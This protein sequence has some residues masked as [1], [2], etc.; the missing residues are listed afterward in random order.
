METR[1]KSFGLHWRIVAVLLLVSLLPLG[2]VGIGS[3]I[4]FSDLLKEKTLELHRSIVQTHA[5]SIDL[6]LAERLRALDLVAQSHELEVLSSQ[7]VLKQLLHTIN[8][9]YGMSFIDLGVI[10]EDGEHLSYTGP[11]ELHDKNYINEPWF[12]AVKSQ[13]AYV[14]DVFLGFRLVPHCIIAVKRHQ[15]AHWW[16]LRATIN[17]AE[18][19]KLVQPGQIGKTGDTFIVNSEGLYQTPSKSGKVMEKSSITS[20]Q[21]HAEVQH[22]RVSEHG[23][24]MLRATSWLNAG[25]WMLVVQQNEAEIQAP[26][27]HAMLRGFLVILVAVGLVVG[28]TIFATWHLTG[29]IDQANA[30]REK[31]SRD[32][33][34]SAKLAS[35]GEISS[36]LAHEINNPLAIMGAEH[37]NIADMV[38]ELDSDA[39][40]RDE[41]LESIDRCKRQVERCG[42]ITAKMLQFGRNTESRLQLTDISPKLLD[43][44]SLM[45]KQAR[46][47][48]IDLLVNIN[49]KNAIPK[50]LVDPSEL[51][52]VLVNLINNAFYAIKNE[53]QIEISTRLQAGEVLLTVSDNGA[54]IAPEDVDKIFQPFFTTKAQGEGTGLGLSVCYGIVRMWGGNIEAKSE[55]GKGTVMTI[56]LPVPTQNQ[57]GRKI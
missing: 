22:S 53:G 18:F 39:P 34:R 17:S 3:R 11:Y 54:G 13:G 28:T 49:S 29:Q 50:V 55:L 38:S 51:D 25:R 9:S 36:G 26:I 41:L 37:T 57:Y 47:R 20:P 30:Q 24:S 40:T 8:I 45:Q 52:Q 16:I 35:L 4:V 23:A 7:E 43:I 1:V 56:R 32:L 2:L 19:E 42:N 12:Q 27:R 15:G 44:A 21:M 46:V 33:L 48:N 5:R 14:S 31:L 10:N 6:Y